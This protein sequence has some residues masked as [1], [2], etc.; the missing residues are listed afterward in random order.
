MIIVEKVGKTSKE[1]LSEIQN[2][3]SL[4]LQTASLMYILLDATQYKCVHT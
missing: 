2:I 4:H 3:K 1:K